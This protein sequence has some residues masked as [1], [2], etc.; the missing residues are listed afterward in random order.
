MGM[1]GFFGQ[2]TVMKAEYTYDTVIEI[3]ANMISRKEYDTDMLTIKAEM[4]LL[5]SRIIAIELAMEKGNH[6][7]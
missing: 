4:N 1:V 2:K 6:H 5:R 3:K 7:Q